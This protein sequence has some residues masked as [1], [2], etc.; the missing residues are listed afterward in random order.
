MDFSSTRAEHYEISWIEAYMK[1]HTIEEKLYQVLVSDDMMR[2]LQALNTGALSSGGSAMSSG[3][4]T[5]VLTADKRYIEGTAVHDGGVMTATQRLKL[6]AVAMRNAWTHPGVA[7]VG[8]DDNPFQSLIF[9]PIFQY[10]PAC[11][12]HFLRILAN[13]MEMNFEQFLTF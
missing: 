12:V 7:V 2:T 9:L 1:W 3:D 8:S 5:V 4:S 10:L 13:S 11:R 6:K